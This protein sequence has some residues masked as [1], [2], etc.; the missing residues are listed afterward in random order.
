MIN[1]GDT[2]YTFQGELLLELLVLDIIDENVLSAGNADCTCVAWKNYCYSSP[3]EAFKNMQKAML[4]IRK[5]Y[6]F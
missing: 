2:I 4:A 3:E 6:D 1:P 5:K